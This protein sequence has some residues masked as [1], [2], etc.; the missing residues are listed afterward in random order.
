LNFLRL[1]WFDLGIVL[2]VVV[3]VFVLIAHPTGLALLLWISL[4][5]LF[6]HQFEE[7]RYHGYFPGMLT[8]DLLLLP[9]AVNFFFLVI[10]GQLAVLLDWGPGHHFGNCA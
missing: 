6:L 5:S 10:H 4:A 2:A 1:H 7:N 3:G 9:I 8:A